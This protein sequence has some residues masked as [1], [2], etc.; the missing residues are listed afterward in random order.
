[1]D[2]PGSRAGHPCHPQR[3]LLRPERHSPPR[4]APGGLRQEAIPLRRGRAQHGPDPPPRTAATPPRPPPAHSGPHLR[5]AAQAPGAR[6][7]SRPGHL[8]LGQPPDRGQPQTSS[9]SP[10]PNRSGA[11]PR[12][13]RDVDPPEPTR[14][15]CRPSPNRFGADPRR[16]RGVEP[17]QIPPA[18]G[19]GPPRTGSGWI[20]DGFGGWILPTSPPGRC[21]PS[22]NRFR[23]EDGP[24]RAKIHPSLRHPV[25]P[26]SPISA[27][28]PLVPPPT[29]LS[30]GNPLF[31]PPTPLSAGNSLFA[32]GPPA[33]RA[34]PLFPRPTRHLSGQPPLSPANPPV[35]GMPLDVGGCPFKIPGGNPPV[36]G[37]SL[38]MGG[39][40]AGWRRGRLSGDGVR[41]PQ[42]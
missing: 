20:C 31:P 28:N 29:P 11:D 35:E 16:N 19:A 7:R 39:S 4:A 3:K 30:A 37:I 2:A 21:A 42:P 33:Q 34:A 1:M 41:L 32:P 24:V 6:R 22:P 8:Q 14:A 23:E 38:E 12:R 5:S 25:I 26:F 18:P 17:P 40:P 36:E 9:P 10:S 15:R 27:G 13:I